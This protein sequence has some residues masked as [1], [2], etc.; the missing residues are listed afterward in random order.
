MQES[1]RL[2]GTRTGC[3]S[4]HTARCTRAT[5][6]CSPA[7]GPR[8][9]PGCSRR[10]R[11]SPPDTCSRQHSPCTGPGSQL[12]AGRRPGESSCRGCGR[13]HSTHRRNRSRQ[14]H[15]S[16]NGTKIGTGT[17]F[18]YLLRHNKRQAA[19]IRRDLN[20]SFRFDLVKRKLPDLPPPSHSGRV[21]ASTVPWPSSP[22]MFSTG[23]GV[24]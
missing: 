13:S 2:T 18:S 6:Y 10:R 15:R 16:L 1:V 22:P 8:W 14:N 24:Q 7:A 20:F 23:A 11:R 9:T 21:S 19:T 4:S 5:S 17:V 12:Q 3:L